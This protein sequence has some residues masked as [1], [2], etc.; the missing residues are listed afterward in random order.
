MEFRETAM[1]PIRKLTDYDGVTPQSVT[2]TGS[3]EI[4]NLSKSYAAVLG[5]I[6]TKSNIGRQ[7]LDPEDTKIAISIWYE[8]LY[9]VVPEQRLNDCYLHAVR[10]RNNTF[11]MQPS[12]LATAWG[13][14]RNSEMYKRVSDNRQLTH[15]FCEKCNNTGTEPIRN[16]RGVIISART[17]IH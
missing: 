1:E 3:A 12:E 16:D 17:C 4:S 10:T 7:Q 8:V 11:A 2:Q 6:I 15:G 5:E 13:E 9:G 14:I